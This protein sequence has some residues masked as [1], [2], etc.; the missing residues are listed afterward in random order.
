MMNHLQRVNPDWN[1]AMIKERV[2]MLDRAGNFAPLPVSLSPWRLTASQWQQAQD[3]SRLLGRLLSSISNQ[4]NWLLENLNPLISGNSLT[5]ILAK[6]LSQLDPAQI[7]AVGLPLMRHDMLLDTAGKWRWVESNSIAAGMGPLSDNWQQLLRQQQALCC[8]VDNPAIVRQSALLAGAAVAM[9]RRFDN[10]PPLLLFVVEQQEDNL[11]DQQILA[12]A[13]QVRGVRVARVSL[14]Q[15]A[16]LPM[17]GRR[18]YWPGDKPGAGSAVDLVYFRTGYNRQDY[19]NAEQLALRAT[20]ETMDLVLCPNIALQLAGSKW[21]QARIYENLQDPWT[22]SQFQR[23]LSL[24][25]ADMARLH[26]LL[27]PA[28]TLTNAD[29]KT[30]SGRLNRGWLLKSEQEGG[31]SVLK[32]QGAI[33]RLNQGIGADTG[34]IV[35]APIDSQIRQ[36]RLSLLKAGQWQEWTGSISELGIFTLGHNHQYGGYLLRS[37]PAGQLEGGVHRGGAV[38]DSLQVF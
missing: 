21:V 9:R 6:Q 10:Q 5:G 25:L 37:K 4:G 14:A 1:Q 19:Q 26:T 11:F 13:I 27:V 38:L 29:N 31:G 30:I 7:R 17:R 32:G 22:G 24:S 23:N 12:E 35:M 8:Q 34:W 3:N 16:G 28:H 15:L 33:D 20:L 2:G 18:L 36:A